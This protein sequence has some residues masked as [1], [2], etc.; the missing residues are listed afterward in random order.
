M[1]CDRLREDCSNTF[2]ERSLLRSGNQHVEFED[3]FE[4]YGRL[5]AI[6]FVKHGRFHGLTITVSAGQ[7]CEYVITNTNL[8]TACG[9]GPSVTGG[10][11]GW[12][13]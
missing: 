11:R 7:C 8:R 12:H 6:E 13:V 3:I 4:R 2:F 10:S 5:L 1:L 9:L